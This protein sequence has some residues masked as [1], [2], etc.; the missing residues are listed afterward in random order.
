MKCNENAKI[1]C[2]FCKKK[3]QVNNYTQHIKSDSCKKNKNGNTKQKDYK[4]Q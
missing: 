3:I 2:P 4:V 1:K